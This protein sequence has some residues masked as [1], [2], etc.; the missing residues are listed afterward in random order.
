[1]SVEPTAVIIVK[2]MMFITKEFVFPE[3]VQGL[4]AMKIL[5]LMSKKLK[6]VLSAVQKENV[7]KRDCVC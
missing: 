6:I 2:T 4:L 5:I 7:R 1:M 3:D